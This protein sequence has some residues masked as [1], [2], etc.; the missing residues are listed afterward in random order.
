MK[1]AFATLLLLTLFAGPTLCFV[2]VCPVQAEEHDCCPRTSQSP[3]HP[4]IATCPF[5][6]LTQS[7][8][9]VKVDKT[10]VGLAL[11]SPVVIAAPVLVESTGPLAPTRVENGRNLHVLNR[12]LRI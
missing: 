11:A 10:F 2:A 9:A 4:E 5:D 7:T 8:V 1:T 6:I 12:I 3:V